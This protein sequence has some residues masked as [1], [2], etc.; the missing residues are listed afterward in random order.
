MKMYTIL[1][2]LWVMPSLQ[3]QSEVYSAESEDLDAFDRVL[4]KRSERRKQR[5]SREGRSEKE[6][7]RGDS[8]VK[9]PKP[10]RPSSKVIKSR[11]NLQRIKNLRKREMHKTPTGNQRFQEQRKER[12]RRRLRREKQ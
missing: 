8:V 6:G 12:R 2:L 1:I 11:N 4:E 3:A 7:S 10:T 9:N 5:V